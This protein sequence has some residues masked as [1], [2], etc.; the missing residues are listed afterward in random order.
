MKAKYILIPALLIFVIILGGWFCINRENIG[1]FSEQSSAESK[2]QQSFEESS[3]AESSVEESSEIS[4]ES[5]E[6]ESSE[7]PGSRTATAEDLAV[8]QNYEAKYFVRKLTDEQKYYFA[9]LYSAA[10]NFEESAVFYAPIPEDDLTTLMYLL[11]YD[12]PELIHINGDYFPVYTGENLKYVSSVKLNYIMDK[13]TYESALSELKAFFDELKKNTD[14]KTDLEKEKYV[15][16]LIFN[17][18][19]YNDTNELSGS[20]YSTLI[21]HFGRCEGFCK[22][23]MWC[24]RELGVETLSVSGPQ[25][26]DPGSA[27]ADHSWNIINLNGTYYHVD[28]TI[29]NVQGNTD[30]HNPPNYGFFNVNDAAISGSRTI[31]EVYTDLGV[32]ECNSMELNYHIMNDSYVRSGEASKEK[33]FELIGKSLTTDGINALSIKFESKEDYENVLLNIDSWVTEALTGTPGEPYTYTNYY[34]NLSQCI[35]IDVEHT[36]IEGQ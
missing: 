7:Q 3:E 22:S 4:T 20:V 13:T 23:F 11:N 30:G 24:M 2:I 34:N 35:V 12:C 9:E 16:D 17:N 18:C 21:S 8:I 25:N 6:E 27:Y 33:I 36:T 29:D 19:I 5:S 32:P 28:I 1:V 26:W 31:N 15:Y 14:G 10:L